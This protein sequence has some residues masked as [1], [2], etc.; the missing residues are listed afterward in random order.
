MPNRREF[1]RQIHLERALARNPSLASVE[2][3]D[4]SQVVLVPGVIN[5]AG[6]SETDVV[7]ALEDELRGRI[8]VAVVTPAKRRPKVS[9]RFAVQLDGRPLDAQQTVTAAK[10]LTVDGRLDPRP[11]EPKPKPANESDRSPTDGRILRSAAPEYGFFTQQKMH[12]G[13][14]PEGG[15]KPTPVPGTE[16]LGAGVQVVVID[17]GLAQSG[18]GFASMCDVALDEDALIGEA[19][20]LGPA[21][22][23]G[24]FIS[25]LVKLIAP[26]ANVRNIKVAEPIGVCT[27]EDVVD[28]LLRA[29]Q[30]TDPSPPDIINLSLGTHVLAVDAPKGP[31]DPADLD[32]QEPG[33]DRRRR[34]LDRNTL[35]AVGPLTLQQAVDEV[36]DLIPGVVIVASA[37]NSD[38]TDPMY[39]AAF[40]NVVGVAALECEGRRWMLSNHGPW[41]DASALGHRLRAEFVSGDEDPD[42]DP[43]RQAETFVGEAEWSGTSF[44]AP[45]VAAQIAI[46]K[47]AAGVT[48][49]RAWEIVRDSSRPAPDPGCGKWVRAAIPGQP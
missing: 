22:G 49:Q 15:P 16:D 20:H 3:D 11:A 17:T 24:T 40:D 10:R 5:V 7:T 26:G 48:A 18:A 6:F 28:A 45:V 46:V 34:G 25:S 44:A 43:D 13:E 47:A 12:P 36:L 9:Q 14:D 27:E 8:T 35:P 38:C 41:V 1:R 32:E 30:L 33:A 23:H 4:G 39:P 19:P 37:G 29:A 2:L 42:Y 21:A 31:G